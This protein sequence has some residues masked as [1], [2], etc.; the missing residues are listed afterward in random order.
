MKRRE[1]VL[2]L[3]G[4]AAWP[5]A[6]R[7]QSGKLPTIGFLG[8]AT[9][10]A[11]SRWTA[12]FARRLPELGWIDGRTVAIEYRWAEGRP[13]RYIEI[14]AEFV[15]LKV[16]VIVTV[17]SAVDAVKQATSVIPWSSRRLWT[18]LGPVWSRVWR[19]RAAT[20]PAC[21]CSQPILLP[22]DWNYYAKFYPISVGWRSWAMSIIPQ[23]YWR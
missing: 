9:P 4:A 15:R 22:S 1:F 21:R 23:P 5:L 20:S 12:A 7:A 14:A 13:E 10:S 6:A 18:H 17:G 16:D 11:W 2:A 3:G 8:G 19:D